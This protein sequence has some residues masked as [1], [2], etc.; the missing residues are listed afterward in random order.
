M[1]KVV[2]VWVLLSAL[3]LVHAKTV[4]WG[5][6]AKDGARSKISAGVWQIDESFPP[7]WVCSDFR[8]DALRLTDNPTF[9]IVNDDYIE[10]KS[11]VG[12]SEC[13]V[14]SKWKYPIKGQPRKIISKEQAVAINEETAWFVFQSI[15][16]KNES[17]LIELMVQ[18]EGRLVIYPITELPPNGNE[19]NRH[20]TAWTFDTYEDTT[21]IVVNDCD[22]DRQ[23][24]HCTLHL[25]PHQHEH[26]TCSTIQ[27][28]AKISFAHM[29]LVQ[30][31]SD[32]L[33]VYVNEN[34]TVV[35]IDVKNRG[36][37]W[38]ASLLGNLIHCTDGE[39]KTVALLGFPRLD[40]PS[41]FQI[42]LSLS[43]QD[44]SN[45]TL[46]VLSPATGA[47]DCV[48]SQARE[49]DDFR[50]FTY[51]R[52]S[53]AMG[54]MSGNELLIVSGEC[55]VESHHLFSTPLV[56]G[57]SDQ[58][59]R[60]AVMTSGRKLAVV[61]SNGELKWKQTVNIKVGDRY[62]MQGTLEELVILSL[63]KNRV[64][65]D[66]LILLTSSIR[67]HDILGPDISFPGYQYALIS[68]GGLCLCFLLSMT[69]MASSSYLRSRIKKWFH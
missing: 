27:H 42:G 52:L 24:S 55:H 53:N 18:S 34:H 65:S 10:E 47:P 31:D 51:N 13:N 64:K 54:V 37:L 44:K 5:Y 48:Y 63:E 1:R 32:P 17:I 43:C 25:C 59:G 6:D 58:Q 2:F 30:A 36:V 60:M 38:S 8:I 66:F 41:V 11:I 35:A 33:L 12:G 3:L 69:L 56:E 14:V 50:V 39:V 21:L 40:A 46:T 26:V 7:G 28:N 20:I 62:I 29:I 15:P 67:K 49:S 22:S 16:S 68:L 45:Q 9:I 57:I 23:H 4:S 61:D 19:K